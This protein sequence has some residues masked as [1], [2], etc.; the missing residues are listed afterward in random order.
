MEL[1]W[2]LPQPTVKSSSSL[3]Q[4]QY[5]FQSL[6]EESLETLRS[7]PTIVVSNI[8]IVGNKIDSSESLLT[9]DLAL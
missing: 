2:I 7:L 4:L 5:Q 3:L 8:L 6:V 9:K 1:W